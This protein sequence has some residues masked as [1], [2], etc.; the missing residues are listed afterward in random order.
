MR[1]GEGWDESRLTDESRGLTCSLYKSEHLEGESESPGQGG[2]LELGGDPNI[3]GT[4]DPDAVRDMR[5]GRHFVAYAADA[6]GVIRKQDIFL[7]YEVRC[8]SEP[9]HY[10]IPLLFDNSSAFS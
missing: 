6:E 5:E 4:N 10:S 2:S 7:F 8:Y 1:E 9:Y 3:L